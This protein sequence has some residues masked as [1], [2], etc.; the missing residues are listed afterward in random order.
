MNKTEFIQLRRNARKNG[1]KNCIAKMDTIEFE[2]HESRIAN[3][4]SSP[5]NNGWYLLP[6]RIDDPEAIKIRESNK[7]LKNWERPI[8]D[9]ANHGQ[10]RVEDCGRYSS[11]CSYTRYEYRPVVRACIRLFP[12]INKVAIRLY[13]HPMMILSAPRGWEFSKDKNGICIRMKKNH[14]CNYHPFADEFANKKVSDFCAIARENYEK[15]RNAIRIAKLVKSI[16]DEKV[17]VS[18]R[19][20]RK[21]GNC[22]PGIT[23]FMNAHNI[24]VKSIKASI[25]RKFETSQPSRVQ[26][27]INV[28]KQRLAE[29]LVNGFSPLYPIN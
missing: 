11:R 5:K 22:L 17:I 9:I 13:N 28:A 4:Q 19:D 2:K 27:T 26:A 10:Y 24:N 23:N 12:R 15:N 7:R 29:S 14:E 18:I 8:A 3:N 16:P 21:A 20:A 6:V 25:L 1:A